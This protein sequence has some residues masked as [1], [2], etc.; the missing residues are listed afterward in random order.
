MQ[1]YNN[2]TELIG[3]TPLLK[4]N[5]FG[6]KHNFEAD[7]FA[8]LEYFNP[9]SSVKDR[10]ALAMIE[11]AE[12]DGLIN[13]T[14]HVIEP[15]SGNTGIGLSFICAVKGYK[16]TL[17]MPETMS[18]ERRKL[19]IALGANIVLTEG[20]K[21]MKGAIE[22]ANQ[23]ITEEPNTFMPQQFENEANVY[24]HKTTTAIEILEDLDNDVDIF[25]AGIGTG[26]TIT[27]VGTVLK[28]KNPNVKIIAVEPKT[29]AVLSG[30][31]PGPHGIQGI[32]AGFVPKILNTGLFDEIITVDTPDAIATAKEVSKTEGLVV[33]ISSGAALF[34]TME[35]AKRPENKGK[36]IV[37]VFPDT[38]ERYLS[39][40][41]F[42]NN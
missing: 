17:V 32:G 10:A 16:I 14:T 9:L 7:V 34:A 31:Q 37:T 25:V 4:L 41:L 30:N 6:Q 5:N 40:A 42:E 20:A 13:K 12:K 15:T 2:L 39:T 35:V 19:M 33:G 3:K 22:K 1:Y 21:G 36:K 11:Q 27:G 38:G 28:E 18:I 29:S 24:A 23:M 8:K 26:G